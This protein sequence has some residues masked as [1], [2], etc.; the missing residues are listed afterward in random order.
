MYKFFSSVIFV[1][2]VLYSFAQKP[3][4]AYIDSLVAYQKKYIATHE[5]VKGNDRK[6]FKFYKP[7]ATFSTVAIFTKINDTA[8]V[9]IK[10]TGKKTPVKY[11]RRYGKI[12]FTINGIRQVLTIFQSK[13][14]MSDSLYKD[15]LF[16]PFTD[17]TTGVQTYGSGRYIDLSI[18]EINGSF[19]FL[20]FNKAYNPY[21]AY[22]TGY[23]CPVPPKENRLTVAIEAGEKTF[24]K[25]H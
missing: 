4:Q 11:F 1:F 5:V 9:A 6:Y 10:T 22:S 2:L 23:N 15:Y 8:T 3:P 19:F 7:N 21:C 12:S 17:A 25:P 16:I 18:K 24:E 13:D 20:D 14:L